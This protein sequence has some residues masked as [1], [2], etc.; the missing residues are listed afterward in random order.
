MKSLYSFLKAAVLTASLLPF[1]VM[2]QQNSNWLRNLSE[3]MGEPV[4]GYE[5]FNPEIAADGTTVHTAWLTWLGANKQ[6]NYRRSTDNG[7][8]WNPKITLLDTDI[9]YDKRYRRLAVSGNFVHLI[10][11]RN[12]GTTREL[13]YFRST[14][15][16]ATFE[17]P[18]VLYTT[19]FSIYELQIDTEG[20]KVRIF[21]SEDCH[22]C[23]P[24]KWLYLIKSDDNGA[25]FE[26]KL[27]KEDVYGTYSNFTGLKIAGQNVYLLY[28]ESIGWWA[29][30]DYEL[31]LLSSTDGGGNFT[32]NVI[33]EPAMSGQHHAFWLLNS[34]NG[35]MPKIATDGNHVWAVWS[36]WDETNTPTVF[37]RHSPDAG[38]SFSPLKKVSGTVTNLHSGMETIAAK[39]DN[40]YVIFNTTNYK[41]FVS[42]SNDG[43]AS[44]SDAMNFTPSTGAY[45]DGGI[46]PQLLIDPSDNS[47]FVLSTGPKVGKLMPDGNNRA[48]SY[49]GLYSFGN[50]RR[51]RMALSGDYL[52]VVMEDGG[53]W[54]QTGVFTDINVWYRR[55][56]LAENNPGQDEL[57]LKMAIVPNPGN[58][59]GINRFD[60]MIVEPALGY[61]FKEAMT[62]EFWVK[63]EAVSEEKKL[64]TQHVV[65]TWNMWNPAGFQLWASASNEPVN[66][67]VTTTGSY[68]LPAGKN[69]A[70]GYWNHLAATYTNDGSPGNFKILLNGQVVNQ[71]TATGD[72]KQQDALWVLGSIIGGFGGYMSSGVNASFDELRFW[73]VARTPEEI[74]DARFTPLNGDEP[75]LAAYYRFNAVSPFGEITDLSGNG[76]TGHLMYKEESPQSTISDLGLRFGYTQT[77]STF[78]FQQESNGAESFQWD[79]GNG[80]TS[81]L[82]N[83]SVTYATPGIY[84]V[85][86]TAYGG[87]MFDTYCEEVEV[88]GIDRIYPTEGGNTDFL[89]LY[90]YGGGFNQ[91]NVVKLRRS[92]FA[93]IIASQTIFDEK[94]TLTA[95]F[96]LA[97]QDVGLWDVVIANGPQ[98]MVLPE[99]F[100]IVPGE[101]AEPFVTYN[102]GG[103]ILFN[104]YTPQTITIGNKA[105]V[106]AHGVLL[107]VTIPEA[108]GN[109]IAFLNLNIL[110]P[111]VAIDHGNAAELEALGPYVVVD[112]LFGK[113]N[114]ARVYTFY[115]PILPARS[116]F[117]IAMRVKV[118]QTSNQVPVNVWLSG[119]F[120]HSPLSPEVQGCVALSAAKA[121]IKSGASF[122]PG[123]ACLTGAMAI[124]S[125]YLNDPPPTPSNFEHIDTRSWG[126]ILGSNLLECAASL[127]GGSVITGILT[128][129]TSGVEAAQENADCYSG[130]RQVGWLDIL[131]YPV[132]SFDPNEKAGTPGF[133]QEGY[134]NRQSRLGYQVRFENKNTATAPAHEVVILDTLTF[135]KMDLENFSFGPFGWGDT[136]LFPLPNSRQFS[137]DVDLRPEKDVIVRVSGELD[138]VTKVVKWRFLS[139]DPATMDLVYDPLGG[140]LPPNVTSPEGEGFVN[141]TLGISNDILNNE[142]IENRATIVFDA[143]EPIVTNLHL[144]TFDLVAP[145]SELSVPSPSTTDT[146]IM[147]QLAASDDGSQ[148]RNV[149]V[150][151]SENDS[152]YVFSHNAYGTETTFTGRYGSTYRFYSIAVDSVGNREAPPAVADA[153]VS[154][155]TGTNEYIFLSGLRM[156]PKP[157][158][159]WLTVE[160]VLK[161]P[162]RIRIELSDLTG[163][164]MG[165]LLNADLNCSLHRLTVPLAVENGMYLLRISDGVRRVHGKVLVL[166]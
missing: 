146:L 157:A 147:L 37:V 145:V 116:S 137:M 166:R 27:V 151:A 81:D 95:L 5:D 90:I 20:T 73:S 36:G 66:A 82:V 48:A 59:S 115:F 93:D 104:R 69:M 121:L 160:F 33:S 58:G 55:I 120:Y 70:S 88:F 22:F 77:V 19:T 49:Y 87:E 44:F 54:T 56:S 6:L 131:Y 40:V 134:I 113:P 162:A 26:N 47:A 99:A 149:E 76:H 102:G 31:H 13:V 118:G 68:A 32:D 12:L 139:L 138:E 28:L 144:N 42:Q 64:L 89:T 85:C 84:N 103:L 163:K 86:L 8:T 53:E 10:A 2:A 109:D 165:T 7:L 114:H 29:N 46:E 41:L 96:D 52:H 112:S 21:M 135:E 158:G 18:K 122:I 143:N 65:G 30:Y 107:W 61:H 108:P 117:D 125:D 152:L 50:S 126:W 132:G 111:Q 129:I 45:L 14:D 23:T 16:G 83:P 136:I 67:I 11:S 4:N 150:W 79:F 140:F 98:E 124:A 24:R 51:P 78:A 142:K 161:H 17:T 97:Q 80:E 130:F 71:L 25:S 94:K 133:T 92:G 3:G 60:N 106:D 156:Y 155:L 141:F 1:A 62:I 57:A 127:S 34:S 159:D 154:V 128:T 110:P 119:P 148:V 164:N 75:G 38:T 9:D 74:R 123:V 105:N 35:Y 39:G 72:L 153:E 91:N 43:G 101:V 63:P 100:S 15:G